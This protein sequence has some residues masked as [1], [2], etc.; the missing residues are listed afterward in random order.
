EQVKSSP[1][2]PAAL[3]SAGMVLDVAGR[4]QEAH[5]YFQKAIELAPN[6]KAKAQAQRNLANSYGFEGDCK[7]TAKY[8]LMVVDY[9]KTRETEEPHNAFYQEGE[10]ANEAARYCIDAGDLDQAEKLYR[11]G[12]DVGVKE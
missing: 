8:L 11:M 7:N 10:M 9:W 1:E 5:N 3:Q 12:H 2:S 6:A 4:Y